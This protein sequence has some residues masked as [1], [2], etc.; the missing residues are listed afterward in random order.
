MELE[1]KDKIKKEE[2]EDECIETPSQVET[3]PSRKRDWGERTNNLKN[4]EKSSSNSIVINNI[5]LRKYNKSNGANVDSDNNSSSGIQEEYSENSDDSEEES[6][7]SVSE[8]NSNDEKTE[9]INKK[10]KEKKDMNIN[11]IDNEINK[12]MNNIKTMRN[13]GKKN[14]I[15]L[16]RLDNFENSIKQIWL[17]IKNLKTEIENQ[18]GFHN[19]DINEFQEN[20]NEIERPIPNE[21]KYICIKEEK[22]QKVINLCKNNKY[23][24]K[25]R[26]NFEEKDDLFFNDYQFTKDIYKN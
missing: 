3:L 4:K 14:E 19:E 25:K 15:I 11:K 21:S 22:N 26:K 16:K 5:K 13:I 10:S 18:N 23:I 2:N 24:N 6:I 7:K 9:K 17:G 20:H 1:N 12:E 8:D